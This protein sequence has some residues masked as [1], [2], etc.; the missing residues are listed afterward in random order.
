[1][2]FQLR[3][4]SILLPLLAFVGACNSKKGESGGDA[5]VRGLSDSTVI[6][7]YNG[8]KVTAGDVKAT[9]APEIKKMNETL[10]EAYKKAAERSVITKLVEAE[11]KKQ[12]LASPEELVSKVASV[13][14]ISDEQVTKF[15]KDND[16]EKGFKDPRTGQRKK[17]NKD[18]VKRFLTEQER[19][20]KQQ[21]FLQNLMTSANIRMKLEEPRVENLTVDPDAPFLGSKSAKVVIQEF[22]DFQCPFCASAHTLVAQINQAYGDK[23][24]FVFRQF[25]LPPRM[26]PEAKP[27]A[28]ASLCA[29]RQGK[30]WP[31]HDTLFK[32]IKE[33]S[34][35]K[36]LAWGK[37]L[38]LDMAKYES[39]VK[40]GETKAQVEKDMAA[41]EEAGVDSTPTFFINNRR[42]KGG[43]D[44]EQMKQL[45]DAEL[46]KK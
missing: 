19:Q 34:A 7:E 12:G 40:N 33:L 5:I 45:I 14:D 20:G 29:H 21:Q 26:H 18:D 8:G 38:G 24:L 42:I 10:I 6:L 46:A 36:Y 31:M 22:S 39:C 41:G 30:F 43:S 27:A 2:K 16:L 32:G 4:L 1:M 17:V 11:A 9:V 28:I 3:T 15:M 13:S 23:V 35:E 37:E 44:F 25:P